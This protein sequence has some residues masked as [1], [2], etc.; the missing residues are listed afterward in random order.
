MNDPEKKPAD[1]F[2]FDLDDYAEAPEAPYRSWED[3][4]ADDAGVPRTG[5]I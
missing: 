3:Q 2:P 5:E 1:E 4:A